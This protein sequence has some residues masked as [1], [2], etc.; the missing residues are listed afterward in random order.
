VTAGGRFDAAIFDMDGLLVDSEPFWRRAE[1]ELFGELGV[2]LTEELC[3]TTMGLRIDEVV[4]HW[5]ERFP[6]SP[7]PE[8][9]GFEEFADAV[10]DRVEELVRTEA[11][12][13]PGVLHAIDLL[14]DLGLHLAVAS[15]SRR[16]LIE[17][18][19]EH[20]GVRERFA[21]IHSAEDEP[22]GKP[23]PGVYLTTATMLGVAPQRCVALEDSLNGVIAAKAARMPCIAVPAEPLGPASPFHVADVVLGSLVELDGGVWASL[24]DGDS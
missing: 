13:L 8:V 24:V 5:Y 14:S 20:V 10:V 23:H 18:L 1:I 12:P 16:V 9:A 4:R 6:W 15:S 7:S 22:F 2:P 19:L 17:A 11:E 21:V 3:A